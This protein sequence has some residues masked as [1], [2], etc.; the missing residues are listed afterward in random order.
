MV[1]DNKDSVL[2]CIEKE[3]K[4]LMRMCFE[5]GSAWGADEDL[6]NDNKRTKEVAQKLHDIMCMI[7]EA[8]AYVD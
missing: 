5:D 8:V 4:E 7:E 6:R 3:L 2:E 1:N